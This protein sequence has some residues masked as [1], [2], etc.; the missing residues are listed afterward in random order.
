LGFIEALVCF[1]FAVCGG[2]VEEGFVAPMGVEAA[3]HF[4]IPVNVN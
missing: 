2:G 3:L 1:E 4:I